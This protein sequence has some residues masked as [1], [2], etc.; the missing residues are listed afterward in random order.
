MPK[1]ELKTERLLSFVTTHPDY[2]ILGIYAAL[3][4]GQTYYPR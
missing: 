4:I 3:H 1:S 2:R